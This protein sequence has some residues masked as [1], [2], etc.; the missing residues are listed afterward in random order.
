MSATIQ[1]R[2][3]NNFFTNKN[4]PYLFICVP[5]KIKCLPPIFINSQ[6]AKMPTLIQK[7]THLRKHFIQ[8]R[9]IINQSMFNSFRTEI[10]ELST[11]ESV[12][13]ERLQDHVEEIQ[14]FAEHQIVGPGVLQDVFVAEDFLYVLKSVISVWE[15][16]IQKRIRI[17]FAST[18]N[19]FVFT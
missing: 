8:N 4:M 17:C 15:R 16:K 6:I 12:Y 13:Q 14:M 5:Q 7:G 19:R 3:M 1:T 18:G 11:Q 2:Y 9:N 10:E